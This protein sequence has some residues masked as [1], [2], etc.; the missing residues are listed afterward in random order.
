MRVLVNAIEEQRKIFLSKP[1]PQEVDIH[2]FNGIIQ[3]ADVY[4]DCC[5]ENAASPFEPI[6][7]KLVFVNDVIGETKK[8][9]F[10]RFNGWK[11]FAE[12][13]L[14]EIAAA[15]KHWLF[16]AE[17]ALL[18]MGWKYI[19]APDE[20]GFISARTVAMIVNEAYFALEDA[21]SSKNEIDT[22]MKLGTNYPYGP[23]EWS[24]I[25]GLSKIARLLQQLTLKDK[26]YTPSTLLLKEANFIL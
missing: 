22:A 18:Q 21:V 25:I 20:P 11:S 3:E 2:W 13:P 9:N 14:L 7:D 16:L 24:S 26:R 1:W 12:R 5:F 10:I 17:Q 23:F 6:T 15:N 8:P 4:I 19:T